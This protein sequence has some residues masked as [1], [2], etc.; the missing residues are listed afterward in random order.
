MKHY[1]QSTQEISY[2]YSA[3]TLSGRALIKI[4]E[5]VTGRVNLIKRAQGYEKELESG[6]SFW[7]VMFQKFGLSIEILDGAFSSIP[8]DGPLILIANHPF[9][10]LDGL[11]LGYIMSKSR[12]DFKILAHKVFCKSV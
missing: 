1:R 10:I 9:G 7:N 3:Q 2:A 11:I 6:Y 4:L 5:N 8:E 12:K